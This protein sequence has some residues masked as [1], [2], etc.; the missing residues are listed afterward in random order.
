M[1]KHRLFGRNVYN[2]IWYICIE[3]SLF[4]GYNYA[5]MRWL[6]CESLRRLILCFTREKGSGDTFLILVKLV[7]ANHL[8]SVSSPTPIVIIADYYIHG[9]YEN[10]CLKFML[11]PIRTTIWKTKIVYQQNSK[12]QISCKTK[13]NLPSGST[14][15]RCV[16][17]VVT[18][19]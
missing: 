7:K 10:K 3:E 18:A 16:R 4:E 6:S 19:R 8:N 11:T 1:C 14:S 5:I 15:R 12:I 17:R 13:T 9:I 2:I